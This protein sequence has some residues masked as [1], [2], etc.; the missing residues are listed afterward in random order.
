YLFMNNVW[1]PLVE[2][3]GT[4]KDIIGKKFEEAYKVVTDIWDGLYK[5]FKDNIQTPIV[6]VAG[7]II[8]GFSKAFNWVK[9]IFDKAGD[10]I[11]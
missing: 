2:T 5:W 7:A 4:I 11:N 8:D 6:K 3:V 1:N 10:G 9:K